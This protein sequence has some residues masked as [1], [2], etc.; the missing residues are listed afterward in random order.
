MSVG[1]VEVNPAGVLRSRQYNSEPG[2]EAVAEVVL[3]PRRHPAPLKG[4]EGFYP[5]SG[6]VTRVVY[7]PSQIDRNVT[8]HV[9]YRNAVS[10]TKERKAR[11]E[12]LSFSFNQR[13]LV[14]PVKGEGLE[15]E[16]HHVIQR[17]AVACQIP[18]DDAC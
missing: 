9:P 14:P 8:G 11:L 5:A 7:D 10:L 17:V 4:G 2:V 6:Q 13:F 12:Q 18:V 16:L 3:E 1:H 15:R